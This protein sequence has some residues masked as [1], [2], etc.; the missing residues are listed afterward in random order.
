MCFSG[1][2]NVANASTALA[3]GACERS[4]VC[5]Q[6]LLKFGLSVGPQTPSNQNRFKEGVR[7]E[8]H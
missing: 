2:C 3:K 4:V 5:E 1:R 7:I 6:G 8:R